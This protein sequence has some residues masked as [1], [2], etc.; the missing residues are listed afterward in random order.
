VKFLIAA[1]ILALLAT[2]AA[3]DAQMP[4][5]HYQG[6]GIYTSPLNCEQLSNDPRVCIVNQSAHSITQIQC[7]GHV[8]GSKDI[9]VPGGHIPSGAIAIVRMDGGD[10]NH[11]ISFTTA[12][13]KTKTLRGQN[14]DAATIITI[15]D[16]GW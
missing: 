1:P 11:W 15:D 7:A 5:P 8:F 3:A 14:M 13:G 2:P 9:G 6:G 12:D 4:V 16:E 10:C